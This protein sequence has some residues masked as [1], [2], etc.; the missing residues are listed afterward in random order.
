MR[1][2]LVKAREFRTTFGV[3]MAT[4]ILGKGGT[5]TVFQAEDEDGQ[6][7]AI[8]VLDPSKTTREKVKRFKNE[9]VF[10]QRNE[11]PNIVTVTDHGSVT[12]DG[13]PTPFYVMPLFG[14]SLRSVMRGSIAAS[15]LL[16]Y[17]GQL[18]DALEAAH[19][20]NVVHRDVKPENV[21]HDIATDTLVLADFGIARFRQEMLF[22]LVETKKQE[23]LANFQYAAPEQRIRGGH[24]DQRADL[25]ALGLILNE[26]A[27]KSVP[28][29]TGYKSIA[30]TYP[31]LE[32]LDGV[33]ERMIRNRAEDRYGSVDEVKKE[34][35]RNRD[36]FI[37][38]QRLSESKQRVIPTTE[39]D[40]PLVVDPP[41]ISGVD[42]N[43]G[44]LVIQ[45]SRPVNSRWQWALQN[46]GSYTEVPG[47]GPSNFDV[48]GDRAT[49][50]VEA[51]DAKRVLDYF[52]EWLPRANE[53]YA[54]Y[55][56]QE[57]R[58]EETRLRRQL[59]NERLMNEQRLNILNSIQF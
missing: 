43:N 41:Q 27:T 11:H 4:D 14:G 38:R 17:L 34:L 18:L 16:R 36:E 3:Y 2:S 20:Q 44:T 7:V 24:V 56:M 58:E 54:N 57:K 46:L 19:L 23:R 1:G 40:D 29:G 13:Q 9:I 53:V 35:I 52:R 31:E 49:V 51:Y 37:T 32:Y 6:S 8:K 25:F 47:K 5:G 26:M 45:L 22:T 33:V 42:W 21:L 55:R 28:H 15:A 59:E 12:I 10:C 30:A 39:V 50:S 48:G